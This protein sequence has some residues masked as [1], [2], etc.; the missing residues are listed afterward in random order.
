[1]SVLL[2]LCACPNSEVAERIADALV[3]QRLAA[4][5]NR[6]VGM[7]STYRW[8]DRIAHDDEVL[9]LIKTTAE[10][11][12]ALQE[13]I[14]SLHPYELPELIAV[15]VESGFDRYLAWVENETRDA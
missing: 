13:S 8:Q 9:L 2:A 11:Y 5:V 3:E 1:M 4:C 14:L 6:I 7:R 12:P 15:K 10:R